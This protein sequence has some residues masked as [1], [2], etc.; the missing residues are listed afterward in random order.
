MKNT[1]K[2]SGNNNFVI[3]NNNHNMHII[4]QKERENYSKIHP[5]N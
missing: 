3:F 5:Q 2:C 4:L 1:E